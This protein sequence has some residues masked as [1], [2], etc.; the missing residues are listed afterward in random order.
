MLVQ[1]CVGASETHVMAEGK[2]KEWGSWA[3]GGAGRGCSLEGQEGV[4]GTSIRAIP[5]VAQR[6]GCVAGWAAGT[7]QGDRRRKARASSGDFLL[8]ILLEKGYVVQTVQNSAG[9]P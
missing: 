3:G 9:V 4:R 5:R 7:S 6:R 1:A 8:F 2:E